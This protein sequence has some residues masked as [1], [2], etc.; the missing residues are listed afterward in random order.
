MGGGA[1]GKGPQVP[2]PVTCVVM[3]TCPMA[4]GSRTARRKGL[5]I[6]SAPRQP[7]EPT[8]KLCSAGTAGTVHSWGRRVAPAEPAAPAQ[9]A[10]AAPASRAPTAPAQSAQPAPGWLL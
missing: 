4:P 10:L 1:T 2:S 7:Q 3:G 8:Q 5:I 9:R 6:N